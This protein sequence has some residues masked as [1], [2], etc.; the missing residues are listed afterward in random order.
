MRPSLAERAFRR[1]RIGSFSAA[2][3]VT[4]VVTDVDGV[5]ELLHRGGALACWDYASAA[6]HLPL[7]MNPVL[8]DPK[9]GAANPWVSLTL[10][11]HSGAARACHPAACSHWGDPLTE[12]VSKDAVFVSP[13]KL[14]GGVGAPGLL[15][16]KRALFRNAVPT[17]PGGGTVFFVTDQDHR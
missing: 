17:Q 15:L 5:T 12:Q 1:T 10:W 13:H 4:G 11:P 14:P 6:A 3:N 7:D 2:S 16:A 9:T 8:I